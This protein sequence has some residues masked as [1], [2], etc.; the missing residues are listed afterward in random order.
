M[1]WQHSFMITHSLYDQREA[2][3]TSTETAASW[4]VS[5]RKDLGQAVCVCVCV[6]VRRPFIGCFTW[7]LSTLSA[8]PCTCPHASVAL[9]SLHALTPPQCSNPSPHYPEKF[10]S[11][12][13]PP[14]QPTYPTSSWFGKSQRHNT[15]SY[16]DTSEITYSNTFGLFQI[17]LCSLPLW[18]FP[19]YFPSFHQNL[20][21][22]L[23]T[24]YSFQIIYFMEEF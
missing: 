17:K 2:L 7:G 3:I 16:R 5:R 12:K 13:F 18:F 4:S 20:Y 1:A 24:F 19:I 8:P 6:R 9:F 14:P 15:N 10:T 21:W 11:P 23:N 22:P